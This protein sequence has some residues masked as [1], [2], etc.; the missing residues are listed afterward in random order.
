MSAFSTG[1]IQREYRARRARIMLATSA[2]LV[3]S[4]V[5]AAM[6]TGLYLKQERKQRMTTVVYPQVTTP[7][8]YVWS[9]GHEQCWRQP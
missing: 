9:D 6:A 8:C 3:I 4:T 5:I 7:G 2:S 1:A